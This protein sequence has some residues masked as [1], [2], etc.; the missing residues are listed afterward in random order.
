MNCI[1]VFTLIL[2]FAGCSEIPQQSTVQA[3]PNSEIKKTDVVTETLP[4]QKD[5]AQAIAEGHLRKEG[6]DLSKHRPGTVSLVQ[7]SSWMKG[8]HWIVTWE[9]KTPSDGGQILVLVDMNKK[10]RVAGGR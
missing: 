8:Q 5:E 7:S 4:V 10:V 6:R 1:A 2:V 9:L 3:Q